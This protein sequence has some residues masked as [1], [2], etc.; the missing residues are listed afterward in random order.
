MRSDI[1]KLIREPQFYLATGPCSRVMVNTALRNFVA[2]EQRSPVS[3]LQ[4][5]RVH[6]EHVIAE[7]TVHQTDKDLIYY[8]YEM[9]DVSSFTGLLISP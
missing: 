8:K 3:E 9:G 4:R 1:K 7:R 6:D 5:T 2:C